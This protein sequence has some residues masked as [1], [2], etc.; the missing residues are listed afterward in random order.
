[1]TSTEVLLYHVRCDDSPEVRRILEDACGLTGSHAVGG[2]SSDVT[3][4]A[5]REGMTEGAVGRFRDGEGHSVMHWAAIEGRLE[6]IELMASVDPSSINLVSRGAQQLGQTPLMWAAVGGQTTAVVKLLSLGASTGICDDRGYQALHHACQYGFVS[7]AHVLIRAGENPG[8]QDLLGHTPLH[9][10]AYMG[11]YHIVQYLLWIHSVRVDPADSDG[12]TPLC[13]A[14]QREHALVM[15]CLLRAGADPRFCDKSGRNALTLAKSSGNT[16]LTRIILSK[17]HTKRPNA[18]RYTIRRFWVILFFYSLFILSYAIYTT[19]ILPNVGN[20]TV[21]HVVFNWFTFLTFIL[22]AR[23]AYCDPGFVKLESPE[24][25]VLEI[26]ARLKEASCS[27]LDPQEYCFTCFSTRPPGSKHCGTCNRCVEQFDHHCPWVNNCVGA[28]NHRELLGLALSLIICEGL[29]CL[30]AVG[31]IQQ[32]NEGEDFLVLLSRSP[33]LFALLIT[34][35]AI[36]L[37]ASSTTITQISFILRGTT[38]NDF[39]TRHKRKRLQGGSQNSA[40]PTFLDAVRLLGHCNW[41]NAVNFL[42]KSPPERQ[43]LEENV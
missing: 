42:R 26:E 24:C 17:N 23:S 15:A 31:L 8:A 39:L 29:F 16:K 28:K 6:M 1:M 41:Y 3:G 25:L 11:H 33:M 7:I 10:G 18:S 37:F 4:V 9:W 5:A 2:M 34:H 22:H 32:R 19:N 35:A 21:I 43:S 20:W 14:V 27:E 36:L 40:N 13:R 38:T 12:M 30:M